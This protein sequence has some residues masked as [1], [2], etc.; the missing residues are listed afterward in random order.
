MLSRD[1]H[2]TFDAVFTLRHEGHDQAQCRAAIDQAARWALR[3]RNSD[4]GFGHYPGSTAP[5]WLGACR[6]AGVE[7]HGA[8]IIG[9]PQELGSTCRLHGNIGVVGLPC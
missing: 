9:V 4:G 1:R 6:P 3:C 7:E 2:A 5:F 8:G